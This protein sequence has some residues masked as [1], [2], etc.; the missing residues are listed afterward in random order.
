MPMSD[1]LRGARDLV[2]EYREFVGQARDAT[3]P[4]LGNRRAAPPGVSKALV[5]EHNREM[6][7][8]FM[9]DFRKPGAWEVFVPGQHYS[10]LSNQELL[11]IR[12]AEERPFAAHTVQ[13]DAHVSKELMGRWGSFDARA[14]TVDE[15]REDAEDLVRIFVTGRILHGGGDVPVKALSPA[16]AKAKRAAGYGGRPIG[17][18][19]GRHLAAIQGKLTLRWKS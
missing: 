14:V 18:R 13:L 7:R 15:L 17:V 6:V 10:G 2:G 3:R 12:E 8:A 5:R 1:A 4:G 19:R 9:K 16:Y 11:D